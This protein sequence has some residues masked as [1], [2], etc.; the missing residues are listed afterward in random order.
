MTPEASSALKHFQNDV[1]PSLNVYH[2]ITHAQKHKWLM[3]GQSPA[4][5]GGTKKPHRALGPLKIWSEGFSMTCWSAVHG[6]GLCLRKVVLL[7]RKPSVTSRAGM[8][9]SSLGESCAMPCNLTAIQW[10]GFRCLLAA[11][12][13]AKELLLVNDFEIA[14][15]LIL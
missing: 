5:Y 11:V 9:S 1:F 10:R 7:L 14:L 3:V 4:H 15:S 13:V 2:T 6:D 12:P 8:F